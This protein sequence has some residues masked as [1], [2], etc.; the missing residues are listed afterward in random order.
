MGVTRRKFLRLVC[1]AVYDGRPYDVQGRKI[2]PFKIILVAE[3]NISG[4]HIRMVDDS[5][6]IYDPSLWLGRDRLA[7]DP[8][9]AIYGCWWWFER[10]LVSVTDNFRDTN[11]K[12]SEAMIISNLQRHA[13]LWTARSW[14]LGINGCHL[15][16]F[17]KVKN[18]REDNAR[19][20]TYPTILWSTGAVA[21]KKLVGIVTW[22]R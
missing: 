8:F 6:S 15:R 17:F 5:G 19:I 7:F 4:L 11:I 1:A 13:D 3:V 18:K 2:H 10:L 16:I 14:K 12:V 9:L 20:S 22:N 21:C